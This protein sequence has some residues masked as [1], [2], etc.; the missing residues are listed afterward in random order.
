MAKGE[1]GGTREAETGKKKSACITNNTARAID[2]DDRVLVHGTEE[3]G[4]DVR[5]GDLVLMPHTTKGGERVVNQRHVVE[6]KGRR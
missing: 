6:Y 4:R 2:M 5:K 1:E 3:T